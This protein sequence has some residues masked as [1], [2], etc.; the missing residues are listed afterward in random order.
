M[1][2]PYARRNLR[3]RSC[4]ARSG[5][6]NMSRRLILLRH[7]DAAWPA[8]GQSDRDRPLTDVGQQQAAAMAVML[9]DHGWA[10]D[11][12]LTSPATR[13][14]T[15][16]A[17]IAKSNGVEPE[18]LVVLYEGGMREVQDRLCRVASSAQTLLVVGHNPTL[19]ALASALTG[20]SVSLGT[21]NA[22]LTSVALDDWSEAPL[23]EAGWDL[24]HHLRPV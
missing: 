4:M 3:Y 24:I 7:G 20:I 21:A 9:S 18:S 16:A 23:L 13:A 1:P 14:A 5:S 8:G 12:I 17:V 19:S 22:A 15:T 2:M 10:P 11:M 6:R